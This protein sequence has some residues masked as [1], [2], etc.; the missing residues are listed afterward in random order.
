MCCARCC[1]DTGRGCEK[2]QGDR[3]ALNDETASVGRQFHEEEAS[4]DLG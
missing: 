3:N 1:G 2:L 4:A